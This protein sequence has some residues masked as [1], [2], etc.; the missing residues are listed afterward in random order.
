MAIVSLRRRWHR[1][2]PNSIGWQL[3][4][5]YAGIAL[6]AVVALSGLLLLTLRSHYS[7]VERRYLEATAHEMSRSVERIYRDREVL[8]SDIFQSA[9]NVYSFLTRVRVRFMDADGQLIA[10]SGDTAAENVL[11]IDFRGGGQPQVDADDTATFLRIERGAGLNT[12]V[13]PSEGAQRYPIDM[14]PESIDRLAWGILADQSRTNLRASLT[15]HNEDGTVIG[16]VELS[17]SPAF[18]GEIIR[19]V[20]GKAAV[21]GGIA[22]LLAGA[23]GWVVSRRISQPVLL[24][25]DTTRHMADGDLSARVAL[26]R[27]DEFGLLAQAFNTMAERVETTVT[28]LR[29]FVADAAHEISTPIT[30]LRTNLELA[31]E[32][33]TTNAQADI[34]RALAELDRLQALAQGL[35]TLSRLESRDTERVRLPVDVAELAR[36]MIERCASRAEQNNV[37]LALQGAGSTPVIVQADEHQIMRVLDNL[38]DNALKFTPPGGTV[39]LGVAAEA[40]TA[41]L[42]VSDT[43]IGI[44]DEDLPR[45]FSRFHR[46]RNTSSYPGSGLGLVITKAIVIEHG[47]QIAVES[48]PGGTQF[49]VRLPRDG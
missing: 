46:G 16:Y 19:D 42:R 29:R 40:G 26:D 30:A 6:L 14:P 47:G 32:G 28:T 27:R 7:S 44:P 15:L 31:A 9:A 2:N 25:A 24:L 37:T 36:Q 1:A 34:K 41:A 18:G 38:L 8:N 39:T 49:T 10:D 12:T 33:D 11:S 3:P 35:L 5:T 22:V 45:L 4:L 20:A 23:A 21:A 17:E 48:H 43:G 13:P